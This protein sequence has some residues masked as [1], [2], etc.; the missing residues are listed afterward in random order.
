MRAFPPLARQFQFQ[1]GAIKSVNTWYHIAAT[2]EFQ[3]QLGAIKRCVSRVFSDDRLWF[4]FQLGAIKS[5]SLNSIEVQYVAFQFQLGAIK[6]LIISLFVRILKSFN[7]NQ[8]QLKGERAREG[9]QKGC[10]FNSN[11]V[12]LKGQGAYLSP[13]HFQGFQFQLGA[14]KSVLV[15]VNDHTVITFQFQL[16]AIKRIMH[17]IKKIL[18]MG[19]NSNQVQLKVTR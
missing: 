17:G 7:S 5:D 13:I 3:F 10:C 2:Y 9:H 4:Q 16:G 6:S 11:Q 8:V 19:F 15:E 12:Q 18:K 14:I 1:L